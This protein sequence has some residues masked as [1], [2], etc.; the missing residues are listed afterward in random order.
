MVE[1]LTSIHL[2]EL[3]PMA[4]SRGGAEA[5]V[6]R[7]GIDYGCPGGGGFPGLYR[8]WF[9]TRAP[10]VFPPIRWFGRRGDLCGCSAAFLSVFSVARR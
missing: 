8:K 5:W 6:P 2:A 4:T 3:D 10:G 7:D 9:A 1:D